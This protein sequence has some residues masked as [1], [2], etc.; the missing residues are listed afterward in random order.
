MKL[1]LLAMRLV[2][3]TITNLV[4]RIANFRPHSLASFIER[5]FEKC[6]NIQKFSIVPHA[7]QIKSLIAREVRRAVNRI[8]LKLMY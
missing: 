4:F 7:F 1:K 8:R 2:G 6:I 5:V 3:N